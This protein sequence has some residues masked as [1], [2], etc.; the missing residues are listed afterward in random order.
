MT[1]HIISFDVATMFD[2]MSDEQIQAY[3]KANPDKAESINTILEANR[4]AKQEQQELDDFLD[5]LATIELPDPPEGVLNIYC[6]FVKETRPLT[7]AEKAEVK[8]TTPNITDELLN[9]RVVETGRKAWK[10]WETN[11]AMTTTKALASGTKTRTR[12]LAITLNKRDGNTITP[13]GNFRTSK[14][15]CEHLGI[16][17]G[18]DS[19]RRVLE[20]KHYIVDDY[21][22]DQFL[23]PE[24]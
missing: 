5:L 3:I 9:A 7:D 23:T 20:A 17:T 12:K 11:K 10:A 19:A 22:G 16:E 21:D 2:M 6:A 4:K 18:R 13:I 14:E 24:K 1:E 8:K 15:A